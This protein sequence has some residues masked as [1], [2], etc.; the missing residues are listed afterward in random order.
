M[1]NS[2]LLAALQSMAYDLE[3]EKTQYAKNTQDTN[4]LSA[5]VTQ[6]AHD[7]GS[8]RKEPWIHMLI[9]SQRNRSI[10]LYPKVTKCNR[11]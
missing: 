4:S 2:M 9:F 3:C 6:T 11:V 7:R 10:G 8:Q 1:L 5:S